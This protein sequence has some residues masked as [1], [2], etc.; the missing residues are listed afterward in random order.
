MNLDLHLV[1]LVQ[2][3]AER[4]PDALAVIESREQAV[5]YRTLM[6]RADDVCTF[7]LDRGCRPET[8]IGIV[9]P[10]TADMIAVML[11]ILKAG[12]AYVPVDPDDPPLRQQRILSTSGTTLVLTDAKRR[13]QLRHLRDD[14]VWMDI[15]DLPHRDPAP[16]LACAPGG[17]R[18]AYVL[19]TSGST[20]DP[21]GVEIE[22]RSV[23]NLLEAAHGL[24]DITARDCFLATATIGFDIS[25]VEIFLPLI[26]GG[27]L[28]LRD[29]SSWLAPRTLVREILEYGVTVV[30]TGPSTW[31]MLLAELPEF[32]KV[33]VVISTA[34]AITPGLARRLVDCGE[35]AWNFYGP[36]ET[37]VW[38]TAYRM[39]RE[40]LEH[41]EHTA[42]SVAIGHPI[43][44]TEL[45][46]INEAGQPV[47]PGEAGE[48]CIGGL[49]LARGYRNRPDLTAAKFTPLGAEGRRFYR[50]G[51]L[52][53][54]SADGN[55][56]YLGRMDDQLKIR[57]HRIEPGEIESALLA[58]DGVRQ[59][60]VTWFDAANGSRSIL[61]AVVHSPGATFSARALRQQ[62]S[63]L[64]PE[65][66]QPSRYVFCATL[67]LSPAG[68]VDRAALRAMPASEATSTPESETAL[69]ETEGKLAAIW[70]TILQL[71]VLDRDAHFFTS[72]GDSLA[73][74]RMLNQV[75][76]HFGVE[77]PA[78]AVFDAPT[79]Q[80]FARVL[81]RARRRVQPGRS[82]FR[83]ALTR[84]FQRRPPEAAEPDAPGYATTMPEVLT[85]QRHYLASWKGQRRRA[86]ALV[87]TLNENGARPGLFWCLQGYREL[88][89]LAHHLGEQQPIHGLR[90]GYLLV[91][92]NNQP[93]LDA[94]AE[95]YADEIEAL[96]PTAA[97]LL[98]GNCQGGLVM[99]HVAQRLIARG[100][101]VRLLIRMEAHHE[102]QPY[103][104]RAA[105]IFG[106][107]SHLNPYRAPG[108][109]P[110]ATFARG[111][112]A[113]YT[114]DFID[115]AHGAFFE[116]P[117]VESLAVVLRK[118]LAD[119]AEATPRVQGETAVPS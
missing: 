69:T 72:G 86:D 28:L 79:L 59:A 118:R 57:G 91:D 53:A 94:L 76:S 17:N 51:D 41:H 61:A 40:T 8:L 5:T 43:A 50:T 33:R 67:P 107:E 81:D 106:R 58:Q 26:T 49:G 44:N 108:A 34:E 64:L 80:E 90:S 114:V 35:A 95:W 103:P 1:A 20:G 93:L 48:L 62:L 3:Q 111:Y 78:R 39:T 97:L 74:V 24:L 19:F 47:P 88:T 38:S 18:L 109:D 89:Q 31:A 77:L 37:T 68:K 27:R 12:C 87:V 63:T 75:E 60:A 56:L 99:Q 71:P 116:S 11:G 16:P 21:K 25:I 102:P 73:V 113:G 66:M 14:V 65:P 105:L 4:T 46:L 70:Q 36:T 98:G 54:W 55:L 32:P 85:H 96:Q 29:R 10:R 42:S 45:C 13:D 22:Q 15:A 92:Y 7:L 115:G 112:P 23:V 30:Q 9:L 117:N 100:R 6:R 104:R 119:A 82:G 110:N 52:V 2:A 84:W 83:A 101:E